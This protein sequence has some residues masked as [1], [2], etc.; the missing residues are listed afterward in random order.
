MR[1]A[2]CLVVL[3]TIVTPAVAQQQVPTGVYDCYGRGMAEGN[4][5]RDTA[6]QL[7][8]GGSKFSV[9][10][11]GQYLSRGGATGHFRFDGTTLSIT[12]GPY[13]GQ[14]FKKVADWSFRL[15]R[16]NGD[17]GPVSC[18]LNTAKDAHQPNRW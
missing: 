15:L 13:S 11:A 8:L 12:D 10:G 18:P 17:M 5:V 14:R 6:G 2:L 3:T 9:I 1:L 7:N 16:P 4:Q